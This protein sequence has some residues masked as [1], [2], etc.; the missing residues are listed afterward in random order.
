MGGGGRQWG[1]LLNL[2]HFINTYRQTHKSSY[3]SSKTWFD[4]PEYESVSKSFRTDLITE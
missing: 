3:L 2:D 1:F 4:D